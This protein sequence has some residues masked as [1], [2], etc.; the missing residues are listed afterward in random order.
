M[1][2]GIFGGTFDPPHLAHL[3]L[4]SEARFQLALDRVLW[5]LTP[6]PPHKPG[7]AISPL[8]ARVEMVQS[9]IT[10]E[11]AFELSRVDIDRPPPHYASDSLRL[12]KSQYPQAELVYLIGTDSLRDLPNWHRP[13]ELVAACDSIGVM[14]RPNAD[15]DLTRLEA[16]VPGLKARLRFVD[17]PLLEISASDI[18]L[19]IVEGR[20]IRYMV[21]DGVWRLIHELG[22]YSG[23]S[24]NL[25]ES[26][27]YGYK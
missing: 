17:A 26:L 2:I 3:V 22:L 12:L 15:F 20:P 8:P 19:R 5:V 24:S 9:A 7:W 13:A 1:R 6:D 18:R 10:G 21:P 4:A 14:R 11:P 27:R 23:N 25:S 16:Q